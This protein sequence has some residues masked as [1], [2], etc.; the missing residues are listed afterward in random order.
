MDSVLVGSPVIPLGYQ[1]LVYVMKE[2]FATGETTANVVLWDV[3]TTSRDSC[4]HTRHGEV[5]GGDLDEVENGVISKGCPSAD[6]W[7]V[8][9][10]G[11]RGFD[12]EV[13]PFGFGVPHSP[14]K[15]LGSGDGLAKGKAFELN[16]VN[17]EEGHVRMQEG[18]ELTSKCGLASTL[19]SGDEDGLG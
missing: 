16:L 9:A 5:R 8:S 14:Q 4:N 3:V 17:V 19:G 15:L 10:G 13:P 7:N 6:S 11:E 2:L 1:G 18:E 12:R